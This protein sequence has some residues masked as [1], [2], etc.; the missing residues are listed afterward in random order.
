MK[1]FPGKRKGI[2]LLNEG[3]S[4]SRVLFSPRLLAAACGGVRIKADILSPWVRPAPPCPHSS[5]A[6]SAGR[7]SSQSQA[8]VSQATL[9]QWTLGFAKTPS[10]LTDLQLCTP[11]T[12]KA[13]WSGCLHPTQSQCERTFI[14]VHLHAL[15]NQK[16]NLCPQEIKSRSMKVSREG[17]VGTVWTPGLRCRPAG[18]RWPPLGA[19]VGRE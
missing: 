9:D 13:P 4:L 17:V 7:R 8:P 19:A 14:C 5:T 10:L 12:R 1:S 16:V 3:L 2:L 15:K 6:D 11:S 18:P